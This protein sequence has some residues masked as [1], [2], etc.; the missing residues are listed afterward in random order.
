MRLDDAAIGDS[1]ASKFD[2]RTKLILSLLGGILVVGS[3]HPMAL[4]FEYLLWLVGVSLLKQWGAYSKWLR[5]VVPMAL[6]FGAV[7]WWSTTLSVGIFAAIK[8]LSLTSVFF[9]FFA[10]TDPED[11]GNALVKSGLPYPVA[12]VMS[13][14]LQFVPIIS[15]KARTVIDAQRARGIPMEPGWTAI[16]HYPAFLSPLLIQSFKLAEELAEAMEARGFGRQGRSFMITYRFERRDWLAILGG[17]AA[18]M[19]GLL[20]QGWMA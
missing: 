6:F 8:L 7:T 18:V 10:T 20:L 2:P 4:G 17:C 14:A 15:R 19:L 11:L 3:G 12:F 13:T 1:G 16:R 9:I 5:L